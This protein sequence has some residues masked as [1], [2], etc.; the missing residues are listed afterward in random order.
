MN[1]NI[2]ETLRPWNELYISVTADAE[3]YVKRILVL[4][5]FFELY[6]KYSNA[7]S[8]VITWLEV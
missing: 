7:V 5:I 8:L 6:Y 1:K 2:A 3:L 4:H